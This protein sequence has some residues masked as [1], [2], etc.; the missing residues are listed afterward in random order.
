MEDCSLEDKTS[1]LKYVEIVLTTHCT[2]KC[3]DCAN[4]INLYKTPYHI[5]MDVIIKS[6]ERLKATV[7]T[8]DMVGLLGGEPFLYPFL[9]E[10]VDYLCN[11]NKVKGI[12]LVTN[13][14]IIRKDA[15]L[16]EK[17]TN[18]KVVVQV[19]EYKCSQKAREIC[20]VLHNYDI[21][22]LYV[23]RS[24]ERWRK[25][26][27]AKS[28]SL[29]DSELKKQ[30]KQCNMMCRSILNGKLFYCPRSAHGDDI[31]LFDEIEYVELCEFEPSEVLAIKIR[32]LLCETEY[33]EA[34]KYCNAGTD[35]FIEIDA[36]I[37]EEN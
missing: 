16:L 30:F 7:D 29:D 5:S 8:I 1:H 27:C 15:L 20:S 24:K 26:N 33:L 9:T 23:D 13:G 10:V 14:T 17:L 34:C 4:Y 18:P 32:K 12:R 11:Q 6:F 21:R 31:G 3:I 2:L 19:N 22:V 37:Q 28:Q 36:A 25:Y 35:D